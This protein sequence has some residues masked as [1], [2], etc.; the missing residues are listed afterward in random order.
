MAMACRTISRFLSC[1]LP[2][3]LCG[4]SGGDFAYCWERPKVDIQTAGKD[5]ES[6]LKLKLQCVATVAVALAAAM[7]A[8]CGSTA[9]KS[10]SSSPGTPPSLAATPASADFGSVLVGTTASRTV[11]LTNSGGSDAVI[12]AVNTSDPSFGVPG[13]ALPATIAAGAVI[14]ASISVTPSSAG[15]ISGSVSFI[16]NAANSPTVVSFTGT[17]TTGVVAQ[18][19]V[20]P[21]AIAFGSITV[22][23]SATRTMTISNPGTAALTVNSAAVSGAAFSIAGTTFPV[24]INPGGSRAVTVTFSPSTIGNQSGSITIDSNA[25]NLVSPVGL[26]GNATPAPA[27][28]LSA[29]PA[30]LNFG[31]VAVGSN[32]SQTVTLTN[33]G[34]ASVTI[35]AANVTGSSAFTVTGLT[36]P[37]TVAVGA[38][39]T[40][41]V[42]FA[43]PTPGN[44][45]A[46]VSFVS[47]ANNSP[48]VVSASGSGFTPV[49]HAVDL[50][51]VASAS[52]IN[53]YRV[54]RSTQ[55]GFGYQ[56][57]TT[58]LQPGLVFTDSTVLSGQ[59]YF[60]VVTSVDAQGI[61]SIF[62][63]EATAAIPI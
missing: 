35:S 16:S 46:S 11:A 15:P 23:T 31:Q 57:L 7:L 2:A 61:E 6:M 38:S 17:A 29:S 40:A 42:R 18:I 27:P 43:P 4:A 3:V 20:T 37:K 63:N 44:A 30:S 14:S 50:S 55:S 45:S 8:G 19:A 39:T 28:M 60:Y 32:A 48:A 34:N 5:K 22:N 56:L 52:I 33:T 24:T 62:S 59:T 10:S 49:A 53:G 21:A 51:W 26:S 47:N 13:L 36:L 1:N 12:T 41:S 9:A 25:T 54:Y 58:S